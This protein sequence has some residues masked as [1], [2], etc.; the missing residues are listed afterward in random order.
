M[1]NINIICI[2]SVKERFFSDA[3]NEYT[4]RLKRYAKLSIIELDEERTPNDPNESQIQRTV[5]KESDRIMAKISK[6][7]YVIAMCIEGKQLSSQEL[8]SKLSQISMI[9]GTVDFIIGGSWGLSDKLKQRADLRLSMSRMTFPHQLA[10][11]ML[12]EQI[13]RAFSILNNSKYHK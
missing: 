4:K 10:R 9:S 12:C 5:E 6:S 8:A 7:D 3:V 1:L 2:G 11:V 13:Y